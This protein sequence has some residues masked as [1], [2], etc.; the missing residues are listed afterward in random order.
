MRAN[1]STGC[2]AVFNSHLMRLWVRLAHL[3]LSRG[4]LDLVVLGKVSAGTHFSETTCRSKQ[5]QTDRQG[6][7]TEF[8][9]HSKRVC[10]DMFQYLHCIG[11]CRV[12][13]LAKHYKI[14]GCAP[15]SHGNL[16][17]VPP[18]TLSFEATKLLEVSSQIMPRAMQCKRQ[19]VCLVINEMA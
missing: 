10:R 9:H 19:D 14:N 13:T 1:I 12:E 3:G 18:H 6:P 16:K 15:R 2:L 11:A 4:E 8:Y 5:R 17:A 7:R